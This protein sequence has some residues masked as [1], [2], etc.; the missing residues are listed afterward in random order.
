M[1]ASD[2]RHRDYIKYCCVYIP[3]LFVLC[4]LCSLVFA[5]QCLLSISGDLFLNDAMVPFTF[6][7]VCGKE[8][9]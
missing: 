5:V 6:Q 2:L 9:A 7:P 4:A 8:V 3:V 1:Y